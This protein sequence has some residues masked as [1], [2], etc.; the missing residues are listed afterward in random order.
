MST[1]AWQIAALDTSPPALDGLTPGWMQLPPLARAEEE[2]GPLTREGHCPIPALSCLR[3]CC[4]PLTASSCAGRGRKIHVSTLHPHQNFP[5]LSIFKSRRDTRFQQL[6]P[7]HVPP[8][9]T[10]TSAQ[11]PKWDLFQSQ[12]LPF[13]SYR[14][15]LLSVPPPHTHGSQRGTA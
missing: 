15:G 7:W 8:Q 13:T 1:S 6:H 2:G 9:T 11:C 3:A 14:K 10:P 4:P 5:S 12:L